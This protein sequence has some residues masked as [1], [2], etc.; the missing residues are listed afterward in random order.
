MSHLP[1]SRRQCTHIVKVWEHSEVGIMSHPGF[2]MT[3]GV[4]G[5]GAQKAWPAK[6]VKDATL[7]TNTPTI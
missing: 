4:A 3:G 6:I 1:L 7:S 2:F 5:T